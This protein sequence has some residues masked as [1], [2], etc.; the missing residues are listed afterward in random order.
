MKYICVSK[1]SELKGTINKLQGSKNSSL[2][3]IAASCLSSGKVNIENIPAISD[4]RVFID[5][6][7][8]IGV[9]V[10]YFGNRLIIKPE[11]ISLPSIS[12]K[13][14]N[15]VRPS[16]Y[17]IG[18]LLAKKKK[19]TL[20]YPGGDRI[21]KRPIDQHIKGL[22]QM[23]AKFEF[24]NDH[25]TV[26]SDRLSGCEIYFDLN[27]CGGTLNIMMAAVLAK[28]VTTINNASRDPEVVDTAIFLNKMGAKI[29]GAGTDIIR[30]EGVTELHGCHHSVIPDRLIAGFY[31]IATG[32]SGGRVTLENIIPEHMLPLIHKLKE[33]GITFEIT[34]DSI[35]ASSDGIIRP[36]RITAKKYPMFETDFQ[37]PASILLLRAK[38]SS[39]V[40][41]HVYPDRSNHCSQLKKMGAD[42]SWRNGS[43]YI[44]GGIPLKGTT[45]HAADIRS[46]ASLVLAGLLAEGQTHISGVE[47]IERGFADITKDLICLGVKAKM[48]N[49]YPKIKIE[50]K[51]ILLRN[52][53]V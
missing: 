41:D 6:L 12:P 32:V 30:V 39:I 9:N 3:L 40:T 5:I 33:S 48:I 4:I 8:E 52:N 42:I 16:Y 27:T 37:Q 36:T 15:L 23:G 49:H 2:S 7:N 24:F 13:Y 1:T 34:E 22:E 11:N 53:L 29:H 10:T 43:A 45:V 44:N 20:G 51:R 18:S 46:G 26:I 19:I 25:Y 47:H 14:T 17:F 28:G 21:G 50:N 31:L 38:G 35:T